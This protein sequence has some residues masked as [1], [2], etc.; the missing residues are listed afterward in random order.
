MGCAIIDVFCIMHITSHHIKQ[1]EPFYADFGPLHMGHL[2]RFCMSLNAKLKAAQQKNRVIY[3]Y[4]G[5]EPQAKSNA[6]VLI[7]C[8]QILML[9][10]S[11][12]Q[13]AKTLRKFDP[14]T[15]F[16]DASMG[17]CFYACTPYHCLDAVAKAR[18]FKLFDFR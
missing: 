12:A 3:Y 1:Y 16:R 13:A 10:A 7:G 17:M 14:Y 8:F 6:A 4:S 5:P 15:P 11:P 18:K 2:Y 9:K